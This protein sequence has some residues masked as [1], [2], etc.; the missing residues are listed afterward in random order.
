MYRHNCEHV[1]APEESTLKG[2]ASPKVTSEVMEMFERCTSV[3]HFEGPVSLNRRE[4]SRSSFLPLTGG[5]PNGAQTN[6]KTPNEK[7]SQ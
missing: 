5:I 7:K 1:R 2:E 3:F 4:E 6:N